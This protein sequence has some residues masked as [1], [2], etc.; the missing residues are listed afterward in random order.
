AEATRGAAES[1]VSLG[2][3]LDARDE[4]RSAFEIAETIGSPPL[5]GAALRVL[6]SAVGLGVPGDADLGGAREMFDKAIEVLESA[7]AEM[8]LGRTLAAY[9][10][11][12]ERTGRESAARDLRKQADAI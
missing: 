9:A 11:F 4:A 2:L 5:R 8:E 3:T 12:E 10:E 7:G 1:M 6:A